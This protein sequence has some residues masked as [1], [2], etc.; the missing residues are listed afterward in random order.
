MKTALQEELNSTKKVG[1]FARRSYKIYL[2]HFK[3]KNLKP[4]LT[5]DEFLQNYI[6][7]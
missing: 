6:S 5:Q 3:S 4:A 7:H 2:D 1:S